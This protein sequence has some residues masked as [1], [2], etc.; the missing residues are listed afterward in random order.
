MERFVV[1]LAH[2]PWDY[3]V[4]QF[5]CFSCYRVG[6]SR[7]FN[8]VLTGV[9]SFAHNFIVSL[10]MLIRLLLLFHTRL[11]NRQWVRNIFFSFF[12]FFRPFYIDVILFVSFLLFVFV[13]VEVT[14][15]AIY[16]WAG[17]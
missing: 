6:K 16:Q 11:S 12:F 2:V 1:L 9:K 4:Q 3:F 10:H 7:F 5:V 17:V 13:S 14:Q 8:F 15:L